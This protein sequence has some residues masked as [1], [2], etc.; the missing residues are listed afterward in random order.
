L[1]EGFAAELHA[2]RVPF[3]EKQIFH[4]DLTIAGGMEVFHQ[5]RRKFPAA[6]G[7]LCG[8]DLC[9]IGLIEA[10]NKVELQEGRNIAVIGID[11]LDISALSRVS[12]T[13]IKQP[14]EEIAKTATYALLGS[15]QEKQPVNIHV[16]LKP[17]LIVRNSTRR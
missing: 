11:D 4:S 6:D 17:K 14:H 12:L 7:V 16:S 15:I 5:I 9:A 3:D 10:M 13:S 2:R 1:I 8:N